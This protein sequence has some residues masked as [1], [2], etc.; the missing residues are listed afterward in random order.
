V[1]TPN[2][3]RTPREGQQEPFAAYLL[4]YFLDEGQPDGEQIRLAVSSGIEPVEWTPLEQGRPLLT[5]AIGERGVRDPFLIRDVHRNRFIMLAT[6]LCTWPLHDWERAVR[7]GSR[8]II[9][10]ESADLIH[11]SEP[12]SAEVAPPEAGNAWAPKAFWSE[13]RQA[14]LVFWASAIFSSGDR[15]RRE[16]QRILFSETTDFR[17]FEQAHVYQDEGHDVIDTTFL[18]HGTFWYRFSANSLSTPRR[19]GRGDHILMERGNSLE[20]TQFVIVAEDVGRNVLERGEG[21]AVVAAIDAPRWYLL[22][23]EFGLRG[24]QLFAT[25]NLDS[26]AWRCLPAAKLPP[27]A[28][29]GSIIAITSAEHALLTESIISQGASAP[30]PAQQKPR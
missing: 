22:I 2:P 20:D 16:Y 3:T 25:D 8:S 13:E 12:W 10:W 1:N 27:G 30:G 29:H 4:A 7:T 26:G 14:W 6:D 19:F 11:W 23:D 9:V 18:H 28:R 5:S 15:T 21:P 17:S 24:Y